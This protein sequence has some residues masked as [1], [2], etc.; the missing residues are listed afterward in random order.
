LD[1]S[2]AY[3]VV[4]C[5]SARRISKTMRLLIIISIFLFSHMR[6]FSQTTRIPGTYIMDAGKKKYAIKL[7]GSDK[8]GKCKWKRKDGGFTVIQFGKWYLSNDTL[9]ID[10]RSGSIPQTKYIYNANTL[11]GIRNDKSVYNKQTS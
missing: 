7:K 1:F 6:T 10:F 4:T 9:T 11:T 5:N 3:T 8:T 2:G